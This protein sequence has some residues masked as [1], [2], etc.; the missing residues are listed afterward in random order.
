MTIKPQVIPALT[1]SIL[2]RTALFS[3]LLASA[4]S[5]AGT[6]AP[7]GSS[8]AATPL[9]EVPSATPE[10]VVQP[11]MNLTATLPVDPQPV[12]TS[13][14]PNLEATDP[15][16]VSLASEQIQFVEFFRFT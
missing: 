5:P 3:V 14:G 10:A 7:A 6:D 9:V 11:P 8:M 1:Y 16:T 2:L 13:R 15:A 4:C 12:A